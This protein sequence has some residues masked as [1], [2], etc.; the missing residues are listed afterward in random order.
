MARPNATARGWGDP[1]RPGS[2]Q[3]KAYFRANIVRLDVAGITLWVHYLVRPLFEGFIRELVARGYPLNQR[4][5]DWGYNHRDIA[6]FPGVLSNHSWGLAVDLNAITNPATSHLVTD[7]PVWVRA[8]AAK[9]GLEWG[10]SWT[11][12]YIDPMHFEFVGTPQEAMRLAAQLMVLHDGGIKEKEDLVSTYTA[13][14]PEAG[15]T[16]VFPDGHI[17]NHADNR[18][19]FTDKTK[20]KRKPTRYNGGMNLSNTKKW[21][22]N[23]PAVPISGISYED[24]KDHGGDYPYTIYYSDGGYYTFPSDGSVVK[25]AKA[26]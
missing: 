14:H 8:L 21:R 1:G 24:E 7:M 2:A 13:R 25:A 9:W 20:K 16:I 26:A 12:N 3:G 6:R 5:D 18:S 19:K 17:T 23:A 10:G 22:K 15:F 4:A 11:G